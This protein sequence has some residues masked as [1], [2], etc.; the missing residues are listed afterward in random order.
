MNFY[1]FNW[2]DV[3]Q[4]SRLFS[5]STVGKAQSAYNQ[6]MSQFTPYDPQQLEKIK[7]AQA[8]KTAQ[9][10]QPAQQMPSGYF[11][12]PDGRLI[13]TAGDR[14]TFEQN[15]T[16]FQAQPGVYGNNLRHQGSEMAQ[17]TPEERAKALLSMGFTA[18]SGT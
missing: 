6:G 13:S 7:A 10:Q 16:P 18:F 17:M 5:P 11:L 1:G 4:Y 3:P 9:T 14:R 12:A 2:Q 8:A 15:Y